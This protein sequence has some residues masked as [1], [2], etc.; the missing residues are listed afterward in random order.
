MS[1]FNTYNYYHKSLKIISTLDTSKL[2]QTVHGN[3]RGP[4]D[5]RHGRDA[6]CDHCPHL[7]HHQTSS[8]STHRGKLCPKDFLHRRDDHCDCHLLSSLQRISCSLRCRPQGNP[9]RPRGV[10][11]GKESPCVHDCQYP[12]HKIFLLLFHSESRSQ[13]KET[14][15]RPRK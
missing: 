6:H 11:Y 12:S 4:R 1:S 7:P 14:T 8:S 3:P 2:S 5:A 13:S 15:N 9:R 10:Q